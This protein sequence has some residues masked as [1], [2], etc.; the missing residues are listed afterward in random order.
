MTL[1]RHIAAATIASALFAVPTDSL[2]HCDTLTGPVVSAARVALQTRDITPVLKWVKEAD[3]ADARRAFRQTL[4]VRTLSAAARELADRFFFESIVRLH[5]AGEGEP[6]TGL[7]DGTDVDE[8]IAGAD[9]ALATGAIDP[10]LQLVAAR[11]SAG[12]RERFAQVRT[13]QAQAGDSVAAGRRYVEA[14]VAFLRYIEQ[15]TA[16]GPAALEGHQPTERRQ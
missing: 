11:A 2:A 16:T 15:L 9:T 7:K 6:F 13:L 4:E 8:A 14:Y 12:L 3:E 10:L 1:R 5:R